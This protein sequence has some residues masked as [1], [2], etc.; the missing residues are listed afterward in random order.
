MGLK[1]E[2]VSPF[3]G[4][5]LLEQTYLNTAYRQIKIVDNGQSQTLVENV[6]KLSEVKFHKPYK[7][8]L[9]V[10]DNEAY[11]EMTSISN[12]KRYYKYNNAFFCGFF[13]HINVSRFAKWNYYLGTC[14]INQTTYIYWSMN[15]INDWNGESKLDLTN[16]VLPP[17]KTGF[18][19]DMS[20]SYTHQLITKLGSYTA[21]L[22]DRYKRPISI[23]GYFNNSYYPIA[24]GKETY[25]FK[26]IVNIS[27]NLPIV[28]DL[29]SHNQ[30]LACLDLE[31]HFSSAD[32]EIAE[33]FDYYYVEE[34][35][36]GGR[37]YLIKVKQKDAY[38][39]RISKHLEVQVNAAITW[40]GISGQWVKDVVKPS[41]LSKYTEIHHQERKI[42]T[43]KVPEKINNMVDKMMKYFRYSA[44]RLHALSI[45]KTDK[46]ESHA[47]FTAMAR[48]YN[49]EVKE[50]LS[51]YDNETQIWLLAEYTARV[52]PYRPKHD[53]MRLGVPY[54]VYL[55]NI[56]ING[57]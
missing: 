30:G 5:C 17:S 10:L 23:D 52:I 18:I 54:L 26:D 43:I 7:C 12:Q 24:L 16:L 56:I 6:I 32:L 25:K 42:K 2:V 47:D 19:Y 15:Q 22:V 48:L 29:S 8:K 36:R 45:Y 31:P 11:I 35:P 3:S 9:Y 53:E 38:K 13:N 21:S 41:D 33:S 51:A 40:Y 37:H 57:K 55:A 50:M 44:S 49:F 28:V 27:K 34:T 1:N 20:F 14:E 46:D 4:A 39:F